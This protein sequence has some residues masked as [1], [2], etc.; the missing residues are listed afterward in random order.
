MLMAFVLF[1]VFHG[2]ITSWNANRPSVT[3]ECAQASVTVSPCLSIL[4]Q[5]RRLHLTGTHIF[6]PRRRRS[7]AAVSVALLLLLGGVEQNPCPAAKSKL[8]FGLLNARSTRQK[9]ALL[10]DV[11]ADHQLDVLALTETWIPSDALDAVKLD[12]ARAGYSIV[13]RHRGPLTGRRGGGVAAVYR[14][15]VKCTPVDLGEYVQF[16]SLSV[17]IVGHH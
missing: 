16:E 4:S 9:A 12:V 3:H 8:S 1:F 15:S 10:H 13:H 14:D 11:I 7:P 2:L 5:N 17:K 6:R